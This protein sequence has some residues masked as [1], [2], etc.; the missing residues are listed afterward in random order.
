MKKT[1]IFVIFGVILL[2]VILN[3]SE[4]FVNT[5]IVLNE[6][7][8]NKLKEAIDEIA[9]EE[10]INAKNRI[11]TTY[12]ETIKVIFQSLD[13]TK[14]L[15]EQRKEF[16]SH[17]NI[18]V[19]FS[20]TSLALSDD[21]K[22]S[23]FLSLVEADGNRNLDM[24]PLMLFSLNKITSTESINKMINK[25]DTVKLKF[26]NI[27]KFFIEIMLK[28]YDNTNP[29]KLQRFSSSAPTASYINDKINDAIKDK[30]PNPFFN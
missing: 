22:Q 19:I 9:N 18:Q 17:A 13:K 24:V 5:P 28:F 12:L 7:D 30:K 16:E 11:G 3:K 4:T 26:S 2:Y 29:D 8:M 21:F 14:P 6:Y 27:S 25:N 23:L 10:Y 15:G 1:I 20:D